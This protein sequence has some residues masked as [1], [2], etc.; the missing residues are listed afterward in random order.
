MR[1]R[2]AT[3]RCATIVFLLPVVVS[4]LGT[5]CLCLPVCPSPAARVSMRKGPYLLY[6]GNNTSMTVLWQAD[7][8]PG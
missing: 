2:Q 3:M 6:P 8:T 1:L 4:T 7:G 5:D